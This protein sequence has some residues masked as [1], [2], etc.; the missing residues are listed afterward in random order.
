[1]NSKFRT[2]R[3][4]WCFFLHGTGLYESFKRPCSYHILVF[5]ALRKPQNYRFFPLSRVSWS[6][7]VWTSCAV[8]SEFPTLTGGLLLSCRVITCLFASFLSFL[9]IP[10]P[11]PLAASYSEAFRDKVGW[12]RKRCAFS[13]RA[14]AGFFPPSQKTESTPTPHPSLRSPKSSVP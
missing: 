11:Q 6:D 5:H 3:P 13:F 2:G 1:M 4:P 14:Q 12:V 8:S 10:P 9:P 7:H